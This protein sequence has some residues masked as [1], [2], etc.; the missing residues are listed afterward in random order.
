GDIRAV[1]LKDWVRRLAE[2][3][4]RTDIYEIQNIM[5]R[6]MLREKSLYPNVD[7]PAAAIYYMMG[8]P[9]PLYTPIFAAAR[10]VGWSA[11]VIEQ[12]DEN[13]LIRPRSDYVGPR[14][15]VFQPLDERE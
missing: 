14:D 6:V 8:I 4:G 10:I 11:H 9:I 7:F 12:H 2:Q 5:E 15:L 1:I 3:T 13:R